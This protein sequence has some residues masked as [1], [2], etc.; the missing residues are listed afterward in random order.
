MVDYQY[1]ID[2]NDPV[3]KLRLAM[4]SMDGVLLYLLI[5]RSHFSHFCLVDAI[6]QY[7]IPEEK[8]DYTLPVNPVL[9][10]QLV[11]D[12]AD[13]QS[14]PAARSNLRLFPPPL[15]SRQGISQNYKYVC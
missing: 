12:S 2:L 5:S 4:A 7:S 1:Q 13:P 14:T 11:P 10:P 9:D 3:A 8:E 6:R 15:F